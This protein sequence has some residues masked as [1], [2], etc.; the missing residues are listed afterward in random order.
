MGDKM[1]V[2]CAKTAGGSVDSF[3]LK[4]RA[5]ANTLPT[6]GRKPISFQ[7]NGK[8]GG[9]TNRAHPNAQLG[10]YSSQFRMLEFTNVR[11]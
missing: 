9:V 4:C 8:Q 6:T 11:R 3:A 1:P 7:K 5:N 2:F 10:L